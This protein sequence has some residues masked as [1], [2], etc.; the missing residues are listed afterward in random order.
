MAHQGSVSYQIKYPSPLKGLY[1][2][3]LQTLLLRRALK[4]TDRRINVITKSFECSLFSI[5][6][7]DSHQISSDAANARPAFSLARL[8]GVS[9]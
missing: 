8:A 6:G 1:R 5:Q 9:N 4:Q 7:V 3:Q 2:Y